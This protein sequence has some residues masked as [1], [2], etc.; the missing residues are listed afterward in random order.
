[1]LSPCYLKSHCHERHVRLTAGAGGAEVC[2]RCLMSYFAFNA[3]TSREVHF[4]KPGQQEGGLWYFTD[5][6]HFVVYVKLAAQLIN[7]Q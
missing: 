3:Q 6:T 1:M 4:G 2:T 5:V 7:Q